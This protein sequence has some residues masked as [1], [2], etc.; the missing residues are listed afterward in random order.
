M[1][2]TAF[3]LICLGAFLILLMTPGGVNADTPDSAQNVFLTTPYPSVIATKGDSLSFS[4]TLDNR[5]DTWHELA[6]AV[7]APQGWEARFKSGGYTVEEV[8][9]EPG[10]TQSVTLQLTAPESV[11]SNKPYRFTVSAT[12]SANN[13][14]KNLQLSVTL[15]DRETKSGIQLDTQYPNLRGSGDNTF[16]FKLNLTNQSD[17]DRTINVDAAAPEGWEVSFKPTYESK[18]VQSFALKANASQSIDVDVT[19]P[20]LVEVGEYHIVVRASADND[21]TEFPLSIT[22][23]GKPGL[24]LTTASGNLATRASSD[25]ETK[26]SL[27]ITNTGSAPL[28]NVQLAAQKPD[29]WDATFTPEKIDQLAVGQTAEVTVALKPSTR[30][31]AGDYLVT[32]SASSGNA[33]DRKDLRVTVE[34]PTTWGWA[35]VGAIALIVIGVGV[36]FVRYSRR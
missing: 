28:E 29:G 11:E 30:A 20:R 24:S 34:T 16:S 14:F 2:R 35:A 13:I 6:L 5:T 22:I 15:R 32:L 23:Q 1:K 21:Q 19:P 9:V 36:V 10:K 4:L 27:I 25:A 31:L 26:E 18:Q 3:F 7:Q 12:D 17:Q 8:M 33:S